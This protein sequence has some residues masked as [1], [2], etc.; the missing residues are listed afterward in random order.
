MD[1]YSYAAFGRIKLF[2]SDL[3]HV[4]GSHLAVP[5]AY[6]QPFGALPSFNQSGS[7]LAFNH[8]SF[9]NQAPWG[10]PTRRSQIWKNDQERRHRSR[11]GPDRNTIQKSQ[12]ARNPPPPIPPTKQRER[13]IPQ[14]EVVRPP[15]VERLAL[16][17]GQQATCAPRNTAHDPIPVPAVD[18]CPG[19]QHTGDHNQDHIE[20][21]DDSGTDS[22]NDD[23]LDP[24]P[25]SNRECPGHSD[26]DFSHIQS[27]EFDPDLEHTSAGDYYD[28][29]KNEGFTTRYL[30]DDA[31]AVIP[32]SDANEIADEEDQT[33]NQTD[34]IVDVGPVPEGP[35]CFEPI[36]IKPVISCP[37]TDQDNR[38]SNN[39]SSFITHLSSISEEPEPTSFQP[40]ATPKA[41]TDPN[42]LFDFD[43]THDTQ[44]NDRSDLAVDSGPAT[45]ET[46][47]CQPIPIHYRPV[48]TTYPPV[49]ISYHP[50]PYPYQHIPIPYTHFQHPYC[51]PVA[52]P[53]SSS[54]SHSPPAPIKYRYPPISFPYYYPPSSFYHQY[55]PPPHPQS[56]QSSNS[57]QD[58][59]TTS[60]EYNNHRQQDYEHHH[61]DNHI[62]NFQQL[63]YH[64]QYD[65]NIHEYDLHNPSPGDQFEHQHS[66][67]NSYHGGGS[68]VVYDDSGGYNSYDDYYDTD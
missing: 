1:P 64:H 37:N 42:P 38:Q 57:N 65:N 2:L 63:D 31:T 46:A 52:Q 27:E 54:P 9:R 39:Q 24:E 16:S 32:H 13:S 34:L 35:A 14:T 8:V 5:P 49:P 12:R 53:Q 30:T 51:Q 47:P 61:E 28:N 40:I 36:A 18:Q 17:R 67:H 15:H 20:E 22:E 11:P 25:D 29:M 66:N 55:H 7:H 59:E 26:G 21:H 44:P 23:D 4:L 3:Q 10:R 48:T 19:H 62:N 50:A 60:S 33:D 58:Q 43:N 45:Q 56:S 41:P 6:H 68:D